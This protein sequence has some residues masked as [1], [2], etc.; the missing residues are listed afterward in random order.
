MGRVFAATPA[1]DNRRTLLGK[2]NFLGVAGSSNRQRKKQMSQG[3]RSLTLFDATCVVI[4]AIIG[5]GIFLTPGQV[6]QQAGTPSFTL[7]AWLCGGV[8][9]LCGA[10]TF[11]ELGARYHANGAQYQVLRDVFGSG[12]AFIYAICN[13]TAVQAGA[14]GV[15]ALVC[16]N[17]LNL[18]LGSPQWTDPFRLFLAITLILL[19]TLANLA[20]VKWG[21][22]LQNF[23]VVAKLLALLAVIILGVWFAPTSSR[24]DT[25]EV[26]TTAAP[27]WGSF[28]AA[29]VPTLFAFGGWQQALWM[30]GEIKQ[31][32]RNLPRAILVGVAIVIAVYLCANWAYLRLLPLEQVKTTKTIAADAVSTIPWIGERGSWWMAFAVLISALGVLNVQL[33]SGPRQIQGLAADRLL[34]DVFARVHGPKQTPI[35]AIVLLGSLACLLL[36]VAGPNGLNQL[37]SGVVFVDS[38]FFALT[39]ISMMVL[40]GRPRPGEVLGEPTANGPSFRTPLFPVVPGLFVLGILSV[41]VG[42][43]T[44]AESRGPMTI[45][46]IWVLGTG[47]LFLVRKATLK[48]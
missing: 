11:A 30:A 28:F 29:L 8:I 48:G 34:F 45:G 9:A 26:V 10:L 3:S 24:S 2:F 46:M 14:M 25:I 1:A 22:W 38:L 23:T 37:T 33:L 36:L 7:L 35:A 40:R 16:I 13:A 6:A 19:L 43:L 41:L 32:Q 21:A 44:N 27:T 17:N 39:G 18:V 42:I 12:L 5:V 4:G 47:I 20:G 15:I 31:P